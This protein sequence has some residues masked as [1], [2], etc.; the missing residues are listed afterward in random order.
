MFPGWA[1]PL[2]SLN[3]H[4]EC[5]GTLVDAMCVLKHIVWL[6]LILCSSVFV[7]GFYGNSA[8]TGKVAGRVAGWPWGAGGS[9]RSGMKRFCLSLH[10]PMCLHICFDSKTPLCFLEL[11]CQSVTQSI[12]F[13]VCVCVCVC[14]GVTHALCVFT[15]HDK[16]GRAS[17]RERV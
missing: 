9:D 10:K 2:E 12:S 8:M 3:S 7:C 13:Q 14:V 5:G 4:F 1:A 6:C 11:L 17:C 16:I 15:S